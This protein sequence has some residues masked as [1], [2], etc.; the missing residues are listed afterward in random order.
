MGVRQCFSVTKATLYIPG[1]D[2][3]NPEFSS[4]WGTHDLFLKSL[5]YVQWGETW[6]FV[7][8]PAVTVPWWLSS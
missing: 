1:L 7:S 5:N 3:N 6:S 8:T 2:K 4:C